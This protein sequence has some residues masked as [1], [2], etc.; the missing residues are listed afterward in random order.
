MI[1]FRGIPH[2]YSGNEEFIVN[3]APRLAARG[4]AITVYSR[5]ALFPDRAP[6]WQG[7][8]RVFYPTVEHKSLGQFLHASL[9]T[10]DAV[11]RAPDLIYVHALPSAP[12]TILPWL[13][14]RRVVVN[15]DGMDWARAKW[16]PVGQ[17]Y[18][19]AA[20][21]IVVRTATALVNDSQAMRAYYLQQFGR[22][23]TF[24]PYGA[25]LDPPAR[26]ELLA[27]Y[28]LRPGD[29]YLIASRLIPENNAD[30]LVDAFVRSASRRQLVIAGSANFTSPWLDRLRS[31]SDPRVRFLGHIAA[32][33]HVVELH[34][35]CYA[36]LHG[37]SLGG[38]NPS[39]LKALG[40]GNCVV[41]LDNAFNREVLVDEAGM[42]YGILFPHDVT[43]LTRI[44]DELDRDPNCTAEFRARAP[45]RI[46][47]AYNW[48][49]VT[50]KYE[51]LFADVIARG[52]TT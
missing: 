33:D 39:L 2:T 32:R 14:R 7:V 48:E 6:E 36:Y 26:P 10:L 19:R 4:H 41:A 37:H 15:V 17:A 30:L 51:E 9:A 13:L 5:S 20:A 31:V 34:R 16:G 27:Q 42:A 12:H 35:S 28:D 25:D 29:Y 44:L 3:L 24:I 38:T 40:F 52:R 8:R 50:D 21:R 49:S 11:A 18:F 47:R 1:G 23:S 45:E 43:T 46:K 22:D